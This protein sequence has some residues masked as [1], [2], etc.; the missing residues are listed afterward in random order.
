[1]RVSIRNFKSI[2]NAEFELSNIN[3]LIGPTNAGKS[4]ILEAIH[5]YGLPKRMQMFQ[6]TRIKYDYLFYEEQFIRE[7]YDDPKSIFR[8]Y[9]P[10]NVITIAVNNNPIEISL[11]TKDRYEILF[12]NKNLREFIETESIPTILTVLYKYEYFIKRKEMPFS[13]KNEI[14]FLLPDFQNLDNCMRVIYPDALNILITKYIKRFER[15]FGITIVRGKYNIEFVDTFINR[16]INRDSVAQSFLYF[17]LF[18]SA[19]L[20]A[21]RYIE[22]NGEDFIVLLEEPDAHMYPIVIEEF[23]DLLKNEVK[24]SYIILTTHNEGTVLSM[25]DNIPIDRIKI[26][27][28]TRNEKGYT[29]IDEVD[30]EKLR[31]TYIDYG[32]FIRNLK[33]II[34]EIKK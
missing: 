12:N 9:D 5:L 10:K 29:N 25:I 11:S 7:F 20:V 28:V 6:E 13:A 18:S 2:E 26:F 27:G 23:V 14:K 17:V 3:I 24:K 34:N 8:K 22:E 16:E 19:V 15:D 32:G 4:N 33:N 30:I 1:M 21:E 31:D